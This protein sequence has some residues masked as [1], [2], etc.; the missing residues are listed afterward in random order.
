MDKCT[1]MYVNFKDVS[2]FSLLSLSG[3]KK[4]ALVLKVQIDR[5]GKIAFLESH[6]DY[7]LQEARFYL[8]NTDAKEATAFLRKNGF[9]NAF[10]AYNAS[11][12]LKRAVRLAMT[13]ITFIDRQTEAEPAL[14]AARARYAQRQKQEAQMNAI[15][16]LADISN[17][18][19]TKRAA[20]QFQSNHAHK[21]AE[22]LSFC[23]MTVCAAEKQGFT[24]YPLIYKC[25]GHRGTVAMRYSQLLALARIKHIPMEMFPEKKLFVNKDTRRSEIQ[26]WLDGLCHNQ[27]RLLIEAH[28]STVTKEEL[29]APVCDTNELIRDDQRRK[30]RLRN[31]AM[32]AAEKQVEGKWC[33][34][35]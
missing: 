32:V 27:R 9:R 17:A 23:E 2:V 3:L 26:Y 20:Q 22:V 24:T 35:W 12:T 16:R 28:L 33:A 11:A 19:S 21:T 6:M 13:K 10:L 5:Q 34:W 31:Q 30:Q 1:V 7:S 18:V 29:V 4:Q 14:K 15:Q 8:D 25:N